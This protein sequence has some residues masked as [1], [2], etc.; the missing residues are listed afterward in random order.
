MKSPRKAKGKARGVEDEA[1]WLVQEDF[2]KGKL[3]TLERW[4]NLAPTR[5]FC[6]LREESGEMVSNSLET[7]S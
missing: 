2:G 1:E 4:A 7:P 6:I 3:S 5:D